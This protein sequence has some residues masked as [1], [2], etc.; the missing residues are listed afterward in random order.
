MYLRA[1]TFRS[2]L[3]HQWQVSLGW[4]DYWMAISKIENRRLV[5]KWHWEQSN[6]QERLLW[7]QIV[8]SHCVVIA[9]SKN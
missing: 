5:L 2:N 6:S 8:G 9:G 1:R 7:Q 3:R 4:S